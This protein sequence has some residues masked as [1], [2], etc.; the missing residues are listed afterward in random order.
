MSKHEMRKLMEA[1]IVNEDFNNE[2]SEEL[3]EIKNQI[4]NLLDEARV[5]IKNTDYNAWERARKYWYAHI[6]T[7]L[8]DDHNYLGSSSVTMQDTINELSKPANMEEIVDQVDFLMNEKGMSV[9]DAVA[10]VS[11]NNPED[12]EEIMAA[13]K[14]EMEK[15]F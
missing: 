14:N 12:Y 2:V 3:T 4:K 13:V 15:R 6:I 8:D 9:E 5:L 1:V 11:K 7:A 10:E